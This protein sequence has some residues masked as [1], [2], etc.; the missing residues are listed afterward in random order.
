MKYRV[1]LSVLAIALLATI[2]Q[3]QATRTFVS[4][5]GND[6][7]PCSRTAP[8][9]TW[10]GAFIK[11]F[12]GG[13]INALDPGGYGTLNITKSITIDGNG[14]VGST[15]ASGTTGF[16]VNI[17]VNANDPFRQVIIRKVSINGAGPS[18]TVGTRT[19]I[20]GI[21]IQTNGAAMVQIEDSIIQNFSQNGIFVDGTN[22]VNVNINNTQIKNCTGSGLNVNTTSGVAR[23]TVQNSVFTNCGTGVRAGRNSRVGLI[24]S[25][26]SH[27]TTGL[28]VEGITGIAV[29]VLESCQIANNTG[30]GIQA[31][32]AS[33]TSTSTARISNNIIHNNALSGV[34]ILGFGSVE[35]FLN[36]KIVG[37]NPDGCVGCVDI[38]ASNTN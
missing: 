20:N 26:L 24:H 23:V 1:V 28:L 14:T 32:S 5:V 37:N 34:S 3:A 16:I 2:A 12:I 25:T 35:T 18:G 6:A 29:A 11:T 27:N 22:A 38:S 30:N 36:N 21:R 33:A 31:G 19:G 9:R 4:G 17:A 8:C 10:S 13:E 15:L 7:D